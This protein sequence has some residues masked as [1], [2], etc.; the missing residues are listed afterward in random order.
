MPRLRDAAARLA[1]LDCCRL[2]PGLTDAEFAAVEDMYGFTFADDHREF[3]AA[4]L[5]V[6]DD[7]VRGW[8][9]WRDGDPAVLRQM[10]DWPV[11]GVLFDVEHNVMWDEGW[12]PQP[13][14]V[15]ERL[16]IA[17]SRLAGVPR[18]VPVYG[19]R[20][21]PAGRGSCGHPV[22]SVYQTDIIYY[23]VDLSD[24]IHQEFGGPGLER[25]DP[26]W[27]PVATVPFWRDF[28]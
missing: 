19:H 8:P 22:L 14:T 16:A 10:L 21:L 4:A 26:R 27:Q 5:P 25:S 3:L 17:R 18:L 1:A 28:L 24:Y 7:R 23:G 20:Y 11:E 13:H 2:A 15:D 6:D 12:G 9:D